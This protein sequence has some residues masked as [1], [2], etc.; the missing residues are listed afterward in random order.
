MVYRRRARIYRR[1]VSR[2]P[3]SRLPRTNRRRVAAGRRRRLNPMR[4]R[5]IRNARINSLQRTGLVTRRFPLV[6]WLG[7]RCIVKIKNHIYG[8]LIHDGLDNYKHMMGVWFPGNYLSP[9]DEANSTPYFHTIKSM[10]ED[11]R[12]L[13]T[14]MVVKCYSRVDPTATPRIGS[15][16]VGITLL[17]INTDVF[18]WLN[19]YNTLPNTSITPAEQPL[20]T[21]KNIFGAGNNSG[22]CTLVS[23]TNLRQVLGDRSYASA[24]RDTIKTYAATAQPAVY[25]DI[26]FWRYTRTSTPAGSADNNPPLEYKI[27]LYKTL[28]FFNMN[29]APVD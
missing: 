27:T 11:F 24:G 17:P 16:D 22:Y 19:R 1:R 4:R 29:M 18:Q 13:R 25:Y 28:E 23:R 10:F 7:Q 26:M 3:V 6:N 21:S 8:S 2:Y 12:V 15:Y 5:A 14:T 9:D 20:T